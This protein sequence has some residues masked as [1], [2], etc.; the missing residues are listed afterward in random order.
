MIVAEGLKCSLVLRPRPAIR[1]FRFSV[2][3]TM[4]SWAGLPGV[5]VPDPANPS[6]DCFQYQ[7]Q[8]QR[9]GLVALV[10]RPPP[11]FYLA[12]VEAAR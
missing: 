1:H 10:T 5:V 7:A 3:Q 8:E 2:L 11:R 4:K 12:A 9:E 6:A